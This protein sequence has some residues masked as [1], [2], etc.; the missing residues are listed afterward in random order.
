M[1]VVEFQLLVTV[2][3]NAVLNQHPQ[4]SKSEHRR[5]FVTNIVLTV[6]PLTGKEKFRKQHS[7]V[8][9]FVSDG[10]GNFYDTQ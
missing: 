9:F 7:N 1:V 4:L 6:R 5:V 10:K 3:P 8:R 2:K